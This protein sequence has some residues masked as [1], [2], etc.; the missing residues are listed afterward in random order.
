MVEPAAILAATLA[1]RYR[2][3]RELGRGG[4]AVVYLAR[5]IKHDR[6]VAL[7]VIRPELAGLVGGDRFTRE[8]R[9][10]ARLQHPHIASVYDSG[11]T[12]GGQ[13]W[14]TMPYVAGASLRARLSAEGRLP[15]AEAVRITREAAQALE[16]AHHEGVIHRDI[17]PE[18]ILLTQDGTTLVA[19]FGIAKALAATPS[20][21]T[22]AGASLA[23]LT[24]TGLA[25]GTPAYMSP[26]Q[27]LGA[28]LDGRSD[29]YSLAATLYEMLTGK[30]AVADGN[31]AVLLQRTSDP[32]PWPRA[33]REEMSPALETVVRKGL[34]PD[35]D[36]RFP[37][38]AAFKRALETGATG[39]AT[40][41]T[42]LPPPVAPS[43]ARPV[44][45][46]RRAWPMIA[47]GI[48][49]IVLAA[50]LWLGWRAHARAPATLTYALLPLEADPADTVLA[51]VASMLGQDLDN[52]LGHVPGT[53][54]VSS[55][56]TGQ[57][58]GGRVT[59]AEVARRLGADVVVTGQAGRTDG[60]YTLTL[61]VSR[62]ARGPEVR[63]ATFAGSLKRIIG[64]RDSLAGTVLRLAG[65]PPDAEAL[66]AASRFALSTGNA[67]AYAQYAR[68][69]R[70][71][72]AETQN[73][74]SVYEREF[75]RYDSVL[76]LDPN[77]IE[78]LALRGVAGLDMVDVLHVE[79]DAP[80][81]D[82]LRGTST[83]LLRRA[84]ALDPTHPATR[85]LAGH[86][87]LASGDTA[88]AIR[89]LAA[90]ASASPTVGSYWE[91]CNVEIRRTPPSAPIPASCRQTTLAD[92]LN[93][94][95][96]YNVA[97][98][99]LLYGHY[100][101][102]LE[103][104]RAAARLEPAEAVDRRLAARAL[105]GM[106]RYDEAIQELRQAEA[107]SP[108]QPQTHGFMADILLEMERPEEAL[109]QARLAA[110]SAAGEAG[111]LS[112]LSSVQSG[113][114][115]H[116]AAIATARG[117]VA[118]E[119]RN[120]LFRQE[121]GKRLWEAGQFET[122]L[123]EFAAAAK[124]DPRRADGW[125]DY[126]AR[127][128]LAGRFEE[129]AAAL[130]RAAALSPNTVPVLTALAAQQQWAGRAAEAAATFR[131]AAALDSLRADPWG[132]VAYAELLA[133]RSDSARAAANRAIATDTMTVAAYRTLAVA[134][135]G[136]GDTAGALAASD[137]LRRHEPYNQSA[138][139]L[140]IWCGA[141]S[142]RPEEARARL[143]S[144]E[145]RM[146][147]VAPSLVP[148]V[149]ARAGVGDTAGARQALAESVRR[150]DVGWLEFSLDDPVLGAVR[151]SREMVE[152]RRV[153]GR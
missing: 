144:L 64:R 84:Q 96:R 54:T 120:P 43:A 42:P 60:G 135:A 122:G 37:S 117:V 111:I 35:P 134:L 147:K 59:P 12:E 81:M 75:A 9:L 95:A 150:R 132:A 68:V 70:E 123:A 25:L 127:L 73:Y 10:A 148:R 137:R 49:A 1:D 33:L 52:I 139:A 102:A 140:Q 13:L 47:A 109:V 31:F 69:M 149:I 78:V 51:D 104:A 22:A 79:M 4:M 142:G 85:W 63:R 114:G 131:R 36:Q 28:A 14:Y 143:D 86:V 94:V 53:H 91:L 65:A 133:E 34:Q 153:F 101:E 38:M 125:I 26:E 129:A 58:A 40:V 30:L 7:K 92:T 98:A 17:K 46:A 99:A 27:R 20:E 151:G 18:N 67:E 88:E 11:A 93:A 128:R 103:G 141:R 82:A 23:Q 113:A 83:A 66:R 3:E 116:E 72:M 130:D 138:M 55:A 77:F 8:I 152:A 115:L 41:A 61:A 124:L 74:R 50:G 119:P 16:Y 97:R 45:T 89:D 110:D 57:V 108:G 5:D 39:E 48:G 2:L 56:V 105:W 107:V 87:L 145:R 29:V 80:T 100:P 126:A 15:I 112:D 32:V 118:R 19:D 24:E 136:S 44:V 146:A 62:P 90:A 21:G 6:P 76:A 106:R 71:N 121:L